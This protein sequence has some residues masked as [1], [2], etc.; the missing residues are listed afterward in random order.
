MGKPCGIWGKMDAK[1]NTSKVVVPDSSIHTLR[2]DMLISTWEQGMNTIL[3]S[4]L[5]EIVI[6]MAKNFYA[7]TINKTNMKKTAV[8][9][10][11]YTQNKCRSIPLTIFMTVY[12]NF[13]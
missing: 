9:H 10:T 7:K 12:T 8:I 13:R 11:K 3:S 5:L 2:H 4:A 6:A 1:Q